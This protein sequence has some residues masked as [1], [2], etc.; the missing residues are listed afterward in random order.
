MLKIKIVECTG[1]KLVDLLHKSNAWGDEDCQRPDCWPCSSA[2][3]ED[4][5]GSWRQ[6][7]VIYETY[8]E[9]WG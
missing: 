3:N 4:P 1:D 7:S 9:M 2:G 5:K 8:C 6:R